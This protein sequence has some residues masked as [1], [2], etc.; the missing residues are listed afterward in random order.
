MTN[1]EHRNK[2]IKRKP[3]GVKIK[4]LFVEQCL[5]CGYFKRVAAPENRDVPL[6]DYDLHRQ[7]EKERQLR[8]HQRLLEWWRKYDEYLKSPEWLAKRRDVLKRCRNVCERCGQ[9][10]ATHIHHKSYKHFGN[11]PLEDLLGVCEEN[12]M[13]PFI[14]NGSEQVVVSVQTCNL[15]RTNNGHCRRR[16]GYSWRRNG[17]KKSIDDCCPSRRSAPPKEHFR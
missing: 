10:E 9:D 3:G 11:E 1:C 16:N 4:W 12:V 6:F 14:A 7:W 17:R 8:T 15:G 2:E 5:D 13:L